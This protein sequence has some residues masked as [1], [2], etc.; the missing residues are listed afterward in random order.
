MFKFIA[1]QISKLRIGNRESRDYNHCYGKWRVIY[2]DGF[3]SEAMCYDVAKDYREIFGGKIEYIIREEK[4]CINIRN[5]VRFM[6]DWP[7]EAIKNFFKHFW[8]S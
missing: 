2:P 5:S 6:K 7:D 8:S 1:R 4:T 3:I